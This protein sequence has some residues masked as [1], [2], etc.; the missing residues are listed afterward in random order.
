MKGK[1]IHQE[2]SQSQ[3]DIDEAS[4]EDMGQSIDVVS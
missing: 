1:S 3:P 4:S 2:F